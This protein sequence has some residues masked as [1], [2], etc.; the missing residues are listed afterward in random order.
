MGT[1][2][3]SNKP[4]RLLG[5]TAGVCAAV[6]LL[7]GIAVD[8]VSP[9]VAV[10]FAVVVFSAANQ[11][12]YSY[13]HSIRTAPP[14]VVLILTLIGFVQDTL[15]WLLVSW[16]AGTMGGGVDVDG[17]VAALL[18]GMIVRTAVLVFLALAPTPGATAASD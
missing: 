10:F 6:A 17:F 13:P 12:I 4:L 8:G 7:P 14:L 9:Y 1:H 16:L 5:T 2:T 3:A 15:L 18:G 11:L